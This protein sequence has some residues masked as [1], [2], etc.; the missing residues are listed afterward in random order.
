M[1]ESLQFSELIVV[2]SA[3]GA[4]VPYTHASTFV[5]INQANKPHLALCDCQNKDVEWY[6][7]V[8]STQTGSLVNFNDEF[9]N[10]WVLQVFCIV[11]TDVDERKAK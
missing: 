8:P 4:V 7:A 3:Q 2:G 10:F 5:A 11:R 6:P 9:D 1:L